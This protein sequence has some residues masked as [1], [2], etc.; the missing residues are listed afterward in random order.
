MKSALAVI[1]ELREK[2]VAALAQRCYE[3]GGDSAKVLK[4][5]EVKRLVNGIEALARMAAHYPEKE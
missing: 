3:L 4:D 1:D 2:K 5:N